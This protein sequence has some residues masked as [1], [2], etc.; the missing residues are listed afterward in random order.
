MRA[1]TYPHEPCPVAPSPAAPSEPEALIPLCRG[2]AHVILVG[3][4]CQLP[5]VIRSTI[6]LQGG[7]DESLF[8]RLMASGAVPSA[9]LAIQYRMHPSL[10]AFP[11]DHFYGGRL[12][13]GVSE[14]DRP[15]PDAWWA[16]LEG[17]GTAAPALA[18]CFA[19]AAANASAPAADAAATMHSSLP[20]SASHSSY[21]GHTNNAG[22]TNHT[23]GPSLQ[24]LFAFPAAGQRVVFFDVASGREVAG[25]DGSKS[26]EAEARLV[27]QL[28]RQ[29]LQGPPSL[30]PGSIGVV[31]PYIAQVWASV[32]SR[33]RVGQVGRG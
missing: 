12:R 33:G 17:P 2:A 22:H 30:S 29:L 3:D 4:H 18:T 25:R 16:A 31:T 6:A 15:L 26:N 7:L 5:P 32:G 10:S 24:R 23:T 20:S 9:M 11:S 28:L 8:G 27:A 14:L 19:T 1:I 21:A 13:D